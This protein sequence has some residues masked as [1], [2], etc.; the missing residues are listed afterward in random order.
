MSAHTPGPWVAYKNAGWCVR[1]PKAG[2]LLVL[3]GVSEEP[4]E[5]QAKANAH[6]IAAAPDM[7]AALSNIVGMVDGFAVPET[8]LSPEIEMARKIIAKA[9]GRS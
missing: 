1:V 2:T 8:A 9:E 7:L 4:P 5:E 3:G 6:L